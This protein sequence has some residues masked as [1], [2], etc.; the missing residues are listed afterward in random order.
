MV[1][2]LPGA[3]GTD[4]SVFDL[5][6][7][8]STQVM[9]GPA[10]RDPVWSPDGSQIAY[11]AYRQGSGGLYRKASNGT[12]REELLYRFPPGISDVHLTDWSP[13]GRF[14][15]FDMSAV[16]WVLPL[17]GERKAVELLREDFQVFGARFSPDSRFLAYVSDESGRN[18]VYVRA[19]DRLSGRFST[20]GGQ[21][22]VSGQGGHGM[23]H[24]RRDGRE[25]Y[26]PG[27]G[28]RSDGGG[29][30][31]HSDVHGW[32]AEASVPGADHDPR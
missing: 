23:V 21:W 4:I 5:S 6:T 16:V 20:G 32:T 22:K 14:L 18:E 26:L 13:D 24:W 27:A 7:G 15:A 1:Q 11:F 19:F 12:G 3:P 8:A 25:L 30:D 29:R 31:H 10:P 2:A 17:A 9:T 28:W